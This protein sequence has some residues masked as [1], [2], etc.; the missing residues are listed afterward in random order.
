MSDEASWLFVINHG[1]EPADIDIHGI[2]LL[3][4]HAVAGDLTV[5]PGRVAVV[6]EAA[7]VRSA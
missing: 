3:S 1:D 4:G 7:P 2:E 5:P 6:R